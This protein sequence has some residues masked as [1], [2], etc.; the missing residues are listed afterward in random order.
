VHRPF[1]IVGDLSGLAPGD[2]QAL[3]A[4]R[5]DSLDRCIHYRAAST[6]CSLDR[7]KSTEGTGGH[8]QHCNQCDES[9]QHATLA[10]IPSKSECRHM[11]V[12]S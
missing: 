2:R 12:P 1:K 7:S 9:H 10:M 5:I 6:A 3:Y 4:T 11:S 8:C